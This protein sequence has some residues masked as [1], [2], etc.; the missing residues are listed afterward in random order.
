MVYLYDSTFLSVLGALTL[1]LSLLFVWFSWRGRRIDDHPCCRKCRYDLFAL[2]RQT[3]EA[4]PECG[5]KLRRKGA[6][7][8]GQRCK[9]PILLTLG[10]L[11]LLTTLGGFG[12]GIYTWNENF[13]WDPYKPVW[14]LHFE[15]RSGDYQTAHFGW[16]EL[17]RR[18]SSGELTDAQVNDAVVLALDF[19]ADRKKPWNNLCGHIIEKAR[20][21][22]LANDAQWQ[23]YLD[24][25]FDFSLSIE[26]IEKKPRQLAVRVVENSPPRI[27]SDPVDLSL[28]FIHFSGPGIAINQI[29]IKDPFRYRLGSYN[30]QS[31]IASGF[32]MS[33]WDTKGRSG[34][35][36]SAGEL[37]C[38]FFDPLK[39][40]QTSQYQAQ[41]PGPHRDS[42]TVIKLTGHWEQ[43]PQAAPSAPISGK[44]SPP[45]HQ[46]SARR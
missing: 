38:Y 33:Y 41:T 31:I 7:L 3:T 27:R 9:R 8:A 14:Y 16:M 26:P 22:Q 36:H 4:C 13:N 29:Y 21:G 43:A 30:T 5:A 46:L 17:D 34:T 2:D 23:R 24:Q 37:T 11:M 45:T 35:Y 10:C 1:T 15:T 40:G 25:A 39:H 19:Q 44:M 6:V 18:L 12:A 28:P 42:R 20:V 32:M